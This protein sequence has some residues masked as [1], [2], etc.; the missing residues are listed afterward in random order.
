MKKLLLLLVVIG[1]GM[2][3]VCNK[4]K[5]APQQPTP[6][7]VAQPQQPAPQQRATAGQ[8]AN[9]AAG[10]ADYAIGAAQIQAGQRAKQKIQQIDQQ[11][12]K[13]LDDALK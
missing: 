4:K 9:E 7:Q 11:H 6:Q 3:A 1:V 13:Q 2:F 12:N 5:A 8:M 10:V